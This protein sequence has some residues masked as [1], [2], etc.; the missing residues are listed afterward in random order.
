MDSEIASAGE[1]LR[2]AIAGKLGPKR[3]FAEV[4]ALDVVVVGCSIAG[5]KLTPVVQALIDG[6]AGANPKGD[7]ELKVH[8]YADQLNKLLDLAGV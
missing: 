3:A 4:S 5:D 2:E 8:Q 7:P 1:R 6:A